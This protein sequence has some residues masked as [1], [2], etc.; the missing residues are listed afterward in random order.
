MTSARAAGLDVVSIAAVI[1]SNTSALVSLKSSGLDNVDK[2]AGK[3]GALI[4]T[5]HLSRRR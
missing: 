1:Q 4:R 3:R 2:L 5:A